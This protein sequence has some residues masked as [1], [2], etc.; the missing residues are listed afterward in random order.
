VRALINLIL[1]CS[2]LELEFC[3]TQFV[4]VY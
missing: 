3:C 4:Q 2:E 1:I